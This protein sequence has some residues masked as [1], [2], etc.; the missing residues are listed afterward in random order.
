MLLCEMAFKTSL[1]GLF[2]S[3]WAPIWGRFGD[4]LGPGSEP[5]RA[6][7]GLRELPGGQN[8]PLDQKNTFCLHPRV[9][10]ATCQFSLG[11]MKVGGSEFALGW[12][13]RCSREYHL[14][15][16]TLKSSVF[17]TKRVFKSFVD[18]KWRETQKI[19]MHTSGFLWAQ[20]PKT[21]KYSFY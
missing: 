21:W 14:S 9:A 7:G 6:P 19:T 4:L 17:P 12:C 10:E 15:I 18:E 20:R 16:R 3:L 13:A 11:N 2:E 1:E 5:S 8:D